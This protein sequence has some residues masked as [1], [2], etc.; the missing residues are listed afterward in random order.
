MTKEERVKKYN[1]FLKLIGRM[2]KEL[3]IISDEFRCKLLENTKYSR[4][5][6]THVFSGSSLTCPISLLLIELRSHI[7]YA[8]IEAKHLK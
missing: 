6:Q 5:E 2:E 7:E 3:G 1:E 8:S 4:E